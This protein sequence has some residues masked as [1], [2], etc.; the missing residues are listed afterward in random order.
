MTDF[1]AGFKEFHK[2]Y[3]YAKTEILDSD[4]ILGSVIYLFIYSFIL[5]PELRNCIKSSATVWQFD[6]STIYCTEMYVFAV[7]TLSM[8]SHFN[9]VQF[10]FIC[11]A[12]LAVH[13]VTKQLYRDIYIQG[14]NLKF[15]ILYLMR[16]PE[17][18]VARKKFPK[19]TRNLARNQTTKGTYPHLSDTGY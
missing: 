12:R 7:N 4:P 5:L 10:S 6:V 18:T 1:L 3:I 16:V 9:S 14:I 11:V 19:M 15:R 17:A 2:I 13:I 8:N